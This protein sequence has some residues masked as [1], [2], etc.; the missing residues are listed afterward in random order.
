M[1]GSAIVAVLSLLV[2][3]TGKLLTLHYNCIV[4]TGDIHC[5]IDVAEQR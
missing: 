3:Q 4:K 1:K 2:L 5:E